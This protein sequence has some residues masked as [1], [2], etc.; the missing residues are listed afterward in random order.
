MNLAENLANAAR[1]RG[2]S[3]A[4]KLDDAE[5]TY[6]Q[7][8]EA[9]A[10][11]AGLLRRRGVQEGDRV[12]LML[13]NVPYF[14]VC[15]YGILRAGA[16][17]VPMNV[18]LERREVGYYLDDPGAKLLFAWHGFRDAAEAGAAE[19][20]AELIVVEPGDFERT[21]GGA[22]PLAEVVDREDDET[23]VILY[24]S[25]TT[26]TWSAT[27]RCSRPSPRSMSARSCSAPCRSFTPSGR[28]AG[29]TRR[30][31]PAPA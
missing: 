2:D 10:R 4:M 29:S 9:A 19:T 23:A 26:R 24:T 14:P 13:P 11:V 7:L 15:Y 30:S 21:L 18:L 3:V 6:R 20:G 12:G 1:E 27:R 22:D 31:G 8:D 17:V 16:V 28:P 25:G 5:L